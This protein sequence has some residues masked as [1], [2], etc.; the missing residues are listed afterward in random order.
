MPHIYIEIQAGDSFP[1]GLSVPRD[2]V[3]GSCGKRWEA[4]NMIGERKISHTDL[5]LR[6]CVNVR[7]TAAFPCTSPGLRTPP[8]IRELIYLG[9]CVCLSHKSVAVEPSVGE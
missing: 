1:H 4:D 9:A 6:R 7:I 2:P 5:N 8:G 3:C